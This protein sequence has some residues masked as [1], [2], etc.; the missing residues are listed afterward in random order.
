MTFED[1]Y[2]LDKETIDKL[3]T[4]RDILKFHHQQAA[5]VNELDQ[6]LE[7]IFE[8][9]INC[10]QIGKSYL[11]YET[12]VDKDVPKAVDRNFVDGNVLMLQNNAFV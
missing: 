9:T 4:K 10:H 7:I 12:T 6:K 11:Q 8:E 1:F 2:L 3:F 5:N